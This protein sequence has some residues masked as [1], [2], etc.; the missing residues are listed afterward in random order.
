MA[1]FYSKR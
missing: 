1:F